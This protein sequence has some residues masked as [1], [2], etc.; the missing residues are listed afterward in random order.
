MK[1][2]RP[3]LDFEKQ[4]IKLEK[5]Y[6]LYI[7]DRQKAIELLSSISYYDL[8]NGYKD[9]VAI[10]EDFN[11]TEIEDL[12]N[13]NYIDKSIQNILF[14]Y[15]IYVENRFKTILSYCIS[16]HLGVDIKDYLNKDLYYGE[17]SKKTI[18]NI[19][20]SLENNNFGN[21]TK[22]YKEKHNH[23]PP[24]IL[25]KNITFNDSIDLFLGLN[26]SI[27]FDICNLLFNNRIEQKKAF[28]FANNALIIVRKFRNVIAHNL[29]FISYKS[30]EQ[31]T[32]RDL[33]HIY[34]G[35]LIE[36]S[37]FKNKVGKN[38]IYAMILSIATLLNISILQNNF[39][40]DLYREFQRFRQFPNQRRL[41]NLFLLKT[42]IPNNIDERL[43]KVVKYK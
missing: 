37:D 40:Y 33:S 24:W 43:L 20:K 38:D 2:D 6:K 3:F 11:G 28:K 23:I 18:D 4:I 9:T 13:L 21:P 22:H 34:S 1:Y 8:I 19:L 15:S 12:Y 35:T 36:T 17:N 5:D 16:A 29:K 42:K 30:K 39:Y 25:F 26:K 41:L 7:K 32:L 10:D 31:I 27:Q 14:K